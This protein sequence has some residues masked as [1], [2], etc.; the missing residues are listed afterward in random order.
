MELSSTATGAIL[1]TA[2]PH[3][4]LSQLTFSGKTQVSKEQIWP[5]PQAFFCRIR[6]LVRFTAIESNQLIF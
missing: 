3:H 5:P 2:V 6:I 1:R 4:A